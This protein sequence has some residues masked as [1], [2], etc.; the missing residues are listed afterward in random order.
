M[1]E[2]YK[3][4]YA[5]VVRVANGVVEKDFLLALCVGILVI[6]GGIYLG[7]KN[8]T[9]VPVNTFAAAHYSE[10]PN[11]KL[12][13]LS[14]WDG[15]DYIYISVHG[16]QN[17]DL[18][19]FFPLY[20]LLI[21]LGTDL[22]H[23]PLYS[24]LLISWASFVG[25]IYF[26][27]KV[28]KRLF[29]LKNNRDALQGALLFILFP[30]GVFLFATYTESLFAL[31]ALATIYF[32]LDKRALTAALFTML[33]T[34]THVNGV[35][36][37]LLGALILFEQ[38]VKLR[39]IAAYIVIGSVGLL[40]YMLFLYRRFGRPLEFIVAQ[41]KHGWLHYSAQGLSA[42]L[43]LIN[44]SILLLLIVTVLYWWKR[45]KSFAIYSLLYLCVPIIG[46]QFGGFNRYALMAFP[47]QFMLFERFRKSAIAYAIV[48][49]VFGIFWAH[50]VFQYSGGYVG[51]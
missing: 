15:P 2:I 10:E 34:A 25:A 40:G 23:S 13:Y 39:D 33:A 4:T 1:T 46:G 6:L 32:A 27:L 17:N 30:T 21:R 22:T 8:N 24:A 35:C 12:S 14:N 19:N 18:V 16:Y 41:Q 45:R 37:L 49:A 36:I 48:L 44:L 20:P 51:G 7:Q 28:I 26:Y 47:L 9:V 5:R 43:N 11:N 31:F 3:R 29:K 38:K 50:Y 42:E